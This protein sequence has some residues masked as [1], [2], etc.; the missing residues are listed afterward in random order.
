MLQSPRSKYPRIEGKPVLLAK[1]IKGI[2]R[3]RHHAVSYMDFVNVVIR[4]LPARKVTTGRF[5]RSVYR[6]YVVQSNKKSLSHLTTKR[7][8]DSRFKTATSFYS[9]PLS[10][11]SKLVQ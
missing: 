7:L 9:F 3:N 5:Q 1:K 4:N 11:R 8:F 6:M 2:A 10:W